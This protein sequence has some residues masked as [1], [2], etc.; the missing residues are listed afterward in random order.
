MQKQRQ[1]LLAGCLLTA[2]GWL[3]VHLM[4]F[5]IAAAISTL[6]LSTV[7]AGSMATT[8]FLGQ[9]L[10]A[11]LLPATIK[12]TPNKATLLYIVFL[13][14]FGAY[15]TSLVPKPFF[16][17]V[18]FVYGILNGV[19]LY[20]GAT[21]IAHYH[22]R[23]LAFTLRISI[24]SLLAGLAIATAFFL[25][26]DSNYDRFLLHICTICALTGC[27]LL[28]LLPSGIKFQIEQKEKSQY[29]PPFTLGIGLVLF[30]IFIVGQLGFISYAIE[31]GVKRGF[32]FEEMTFS[33]A[34]SKIAAAA[35]LFKIALGYS[36]SEYMKKVLYGTVA[37]TLSILLINYS[38]TTTLFMVGF[39]IW[40]TSV[41]MTSSL[42]QGVIINLNPVKISRLII[43]VLLA[44]S[45]AGPLV[46]SLFIEMN[47]WEIFLGFCIV[48]SCIP[49]GWV[50]SRNFK[51]LKP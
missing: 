17:P 38:S 35:I 2:I 47:N 28:F 20:A 45:G 40:E 10:S 22:N 29:T 44:G 50:F 8:F 9:L 18:W 32:L 7:E 33:V 12:T 6:G 23:P 21:T 5:S 26:L 19:I 3:P 25:K 42:M 27:L 13:S 16:F 51:Y 36:S 31:F 48:S 24:V 11:T 4:P 30:F 15:A 34:C 43:A 49:L 37:L 41:N 14:A 39:F 1:L 46:S